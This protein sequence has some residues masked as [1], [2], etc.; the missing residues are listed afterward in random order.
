MNLPS[1][2]DLLDI[3]VKDD[4][5]VY[6][7]QAATKATSAQYIEINT[8][9]I[10]ASG[11]FRG[12]RRSHIIVRS[13]TP[14]GTDT[15]LVSLLTI[16][17]RSVT[18]QSILLCFVEMYIGNIVKKLLRNEHEHVETTKERQKHK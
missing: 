6:Q 17:L 12:T 5:C 16:G 4:M 3:P 13:S 10:S 9:I 18:G 14:F 15:D 8:H 11:A 7:Q 1:R 2:F